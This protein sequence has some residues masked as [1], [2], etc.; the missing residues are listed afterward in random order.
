[1]HAASKLLTA[2]FI[3]AA[4]ASSPARADEGLKI[5]LLS[6]TRKNQPVAGATVTLQAPGQAS[7]KG[8]TDGLGVV[9]FSPAPFG[10]KDDSS[11]SLII[12]KQGF[13]SLVVKCPCKGLS[14]ALS[15]E[16]ARGTD[17]RIVLTWGDK[18]KDLDS[19]LSFGTGHVYWERTTSGGVKLDVDDVDAF[20]P[21]TIT[22]DKRKAGQEYI[23][24]VHNFS[25]RENPQSKGFATSQA[26]VFIYTGNK[27]TRVYY[28]TPKAVGNLWVLFRI[29]GNGTFYDINE[30]TSVDSPQAVARFVRSKQWSIATNKAPVANPG[31][32]VNNAA[33]TFA[34]H[35]L[36]FELPE[37]LQPGMPYYSANAYVVLLKSQES[38]PAEEGR[39][40]EGFID[41]ETRLATQALLP[42]NKV[43]TSRSGCEGVVSY[44]N[45]NRAY[46]FMAVYAGPSKEDARKLLE[47]VNALKQFEGANIRWMQ[48]VVKK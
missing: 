39:A 35:E 18:P 16:M 40:C 15:E 2:L 44:S 42:D 20:G 9:T 8:E 6:A 31:A 37:T 3:T 26:K 34:P 19:H 4:F 36:P 45:T 5:K 14:Y 43:F 38:K 47:K 21:E 27:L 13:S 11:V 23:Y 41:E 25:D 32:T 48:V 29:D 10:G 17:S 7:V 12:E 1:M 24:A 28:V 46:E 33:Y 30:F 22:V